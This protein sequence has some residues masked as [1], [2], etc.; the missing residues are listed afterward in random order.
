MG[1]TSVIVSGIGFD[2]NSS[3]MCRFGVAIVTAT[4]LN[5]TSLCCISP[6]AAAALDGSS[7]EAWS[8]THDSFDDAV[9][10]LEISTNSGH[11]FT[12]SGIAFQYLDQLLIKSISPNIG[13]Q[14]GGTPITFL[15]FSL[16]MLQLC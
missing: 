2:E 11:D 3:T 14:W 4:V 16:E 5:S 7:F 10:S 15:E 6:A 8:P 9:V 12:D 1:G 13:P